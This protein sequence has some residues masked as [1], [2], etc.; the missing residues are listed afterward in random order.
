MQTGSL[1]HRLNVVCI[2]TETTAMRYYGQFRVPGLSYISNY[3]DNTSTEYTY[4]AYEVRIKV[5]LTWH[6]MQKD[7]HK[8]VSHTTFMLPEHHM[9]FTK[10]LQSRKSCCI[11]Q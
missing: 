2:S 3:G 9:L 11:M 1:L 4:L 7:V 8:H 6:I 5:S 10:K